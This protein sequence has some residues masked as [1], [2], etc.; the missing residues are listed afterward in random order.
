MQLSS[1][2]RLYSERKMIVVLGTQLFCLSGYLCILASI[3]V[4]AL[5]FSVVPF[6]YTRCLAVC[7]IKF[8]WHPPAAQRNLRHYINQNN[9][10]GMSL[11]SHQ[12]I[13]NTT[14]VK[15]AIINPTGMYHPVTFQQ[16]AHEL[17]SLKNPPFLTGSETRK[18]EGKAGICSGQRDTKYFS[19]CLAD[20][21][22]VN[23]P[24][25][26]SIWVRARVS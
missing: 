21:G 4:R 10:T 14:Y 11:W 9:Q 26:V 16:P 2:V 23:S 17:N 1:T 13:T 12:H 15:I 24:T 19:H 25:S 18:N 3:L 7:R 5:D 22:R 6:R 20:S 8:C